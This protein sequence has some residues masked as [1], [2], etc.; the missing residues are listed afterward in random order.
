MS[1]AFPPISTSPK[2]PKQTI[3]ASI[4]SMSFNLVAICLAGQAICYAQ[5]S[6]LGGKSDRYYSIVSPAFI[7]LE[8][9]GLIFLALSLHKKT[10]FR[11]PFLAFLALF[12]LLAFFTIF[13]CLPQYSI[14]LSTVV[15]AMAATSLKLSGSIGEI[16]ESRAPSPSVLSSR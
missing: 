16:L 3:A 2:S 4:A 13:I 7:C 9:A 6:T 1:E 14:P 15:L 10:V 8:A 12:L 11:K 5:I